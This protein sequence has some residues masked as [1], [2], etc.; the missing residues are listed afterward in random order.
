M[1]LLKTNMDIEENPK[2][3]KVKQWAYINNIFINPITKLREEIINL[4]Q[5][6][7]EGYGQKY[8]EAVNKAEAIAN[9][10]REVLYKKIK[11]QFPLT[12]KNCH[13]NDLGEFVLN[14]PIEFIR[15]KH[16]K[17]Q[18]RRTKMT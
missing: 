4:L 11:N 8:I 10:L 15:V 7:Q 1:S 6:R 12:Y 17:K 9:N 3:L 13:Y 5:F 14:N 16:L 18:I 2:I